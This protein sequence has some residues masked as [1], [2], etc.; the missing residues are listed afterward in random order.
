MLKIEKYQDMIF[1][2]FDLNVYLKYRKRILVNSRE[3]K[4]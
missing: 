3:K 2:T 1:L 4:I